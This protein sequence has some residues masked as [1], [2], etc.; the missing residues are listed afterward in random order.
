MLSRRRAL[1]ALGVAALG[2][3]AGCS[4]IDSDPKPGSLLVVNN[5]PESHTLRLTIA[6]DGSTDDPR[7]ETVSIGASEWGLRNGLL[8]DPGVYE[9]TVTLASSENEPVTTTVELTGESGSLRGENL[10]AFIDE[11]GSLRVEVRT[12]D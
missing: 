9:V 6:R 2:L 5:S 12:Y 11:D 4:A 3:L 8:T 1:H 10:E 7:E